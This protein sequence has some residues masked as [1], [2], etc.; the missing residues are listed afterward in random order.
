MTST[1]LAS[2]TARSA[3]AGLEF[4]PSIAHSAQA[5][6]LCRFGCQTRTAVRGFE[7]LRY[8]QR[9]VQP[10]SRHQSATSIRL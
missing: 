5:L 6:Y 1:H 9:Y 8:V 4:E 2:G 10:L 7:V 3:T